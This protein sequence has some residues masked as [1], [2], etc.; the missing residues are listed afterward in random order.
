ME[1]IFA[2][3]SIAFVAMITPGPNNFIVMHCA[4]RTGFSSALPLIFAVIAGALSISLLVWAGIATLLAAIPWLQSLIT[5]IG[6]SYL[7]YLGLSL[8]SIK[9]SDGNANEK[10]VLP[11]TFKGVYL[12]QFLNPKSLVLIAT[13]I[14]ELARDFSA[15]NSLGI[16]LGVIIAVPLLC[17][18]IWSACGH[19]LAKQ[20]KIA[21]VR[22]IFNKVMG[23]LLVLPA[24]YVLWTN[25]AIY[26]KASV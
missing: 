8:M 26:F 15:L 6:A 13:L 23:A 7:I 21:T 19:L 4:V 22:A 5:I 9:I 11:G 17:L 1:S 3:I 25:M 18:L 14:T 10:N 12:F 2:I 16:L 20:L 24:S